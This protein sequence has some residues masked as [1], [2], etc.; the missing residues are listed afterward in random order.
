MNSTY[1]Q[2]IVKN[3][4]KTDAQIIENLAWELSDKVETIGNLL[5]E[6]NELKETQKLEM[7][8]DLLKQVKILTI[9]TL[10]VQNVVGDLQKQLNDLQK[11]L[12]N[13]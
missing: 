4:G 10:T 12:N 3:A 5:A 11:Q 7:K 1:Q 9:Q 6:I 8:T 2:I 13:L